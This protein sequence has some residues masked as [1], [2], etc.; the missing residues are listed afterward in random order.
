MQHLDRSEL[1]LRTTIM[2]ITASFSPNAKL[3]LVSSDKVDDFIT[4][5]N[6]RGGAVSGAC[7]QAGTYLSARYSADYLFLRK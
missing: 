1:F 4:I 6:T 7:E 2:A 3:L 5:S